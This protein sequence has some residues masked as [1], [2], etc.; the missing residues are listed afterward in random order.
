MAALPPN[1]VQYGVKV[2]AVRLIDTGA[3][4]LKA[5]LY[6]YSS[7]GLLVAIAA[8]LVGLLIFF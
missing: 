3:C 6:L 7:S 8:T 4:T 1:T 5:R 2:A